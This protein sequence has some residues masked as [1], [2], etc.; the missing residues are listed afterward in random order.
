MARIFY[1]RDSERI[2]GG[3]GEL[4]D[5]IVHR[6]KAGDVLIIPSVD[7]LCKRWR[8]LFA[9]L[10]CLAGKGVILRPLHTSGR[11]GEPPEVGFKR[12]LRRAATQ[13]A[14]ATGSYK[15]C[16]GRPRSVDREAIRRL[17]AAGLKPDDIAAELGVGKTSVY[18]LLA[19]G[20]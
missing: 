18:D 5:I 19:R 8:D 11:R 9:I 17:S 7:H 12:D 20:E 1:S 4:Y 15:R 2:P 13:R 10:D 6:L 3:A 14:R 16:T